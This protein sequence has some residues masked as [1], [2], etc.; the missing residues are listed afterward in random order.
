MGFFSKLFKP[1]ETRRLAPM[2]VPGPAT[3]ATP[4]SSQ[5]TSAQLTAWLSALPIVENEFSVGQTACGGF[6]DKTCTIRTLVEAI[7]ILNEER[8]AVTKGSGYRNEFHPHSNHLRYM[9][10]FQTWY[11]VYKVGPSEFVVLAGDNLDG[12]SNV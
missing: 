11:D 10:Y 2:G 7:A 1:Q 5:I 8:K 9:P 12:L 3:S 6:S 4:Q